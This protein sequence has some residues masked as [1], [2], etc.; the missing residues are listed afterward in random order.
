MDYD[1]FFHGSGPFGPDAETWIKIFVKVT[2]GNTDDS[3]TQL[4]PCCLAP[5]SLAGDWYDELPDSVAWHWPSLLAEFRFR[6]LGSPYTADELEVI[7]SMLPAP[8]TEF[9]RLFKPPPTAS[10]VYSFPAVAPTTRYTDHALERAQEEALDELLVQVTAM[11]KAR[12]EERGWRT[13]MTVCAMGAAWCAQQWQARLK[14]ARMLKKLEEATEAR[15][16]EAQRVEELRAAFRAERAVQRSQFHEE[17]AR[18]REARRAARKAEAEEEIRRREELTRAT[19]ADDAHQRPYT[20]STTTTTPLTPSP[21]TTSTTATMLPTPPHIPVTS[22]QTTVDSVLGTTAKKPPNIPYVEGWGVEMSVPQETVDIEVD[23]V[24]TAIDDRPALTKHPTMIASTTQPLPSS[25]V[26]NDPPP[27][28][29]YPVPNDLPAPVKHPTPELMS[30]TNDH[31]TDTDDRSPPTKPLATRENVS[32][33]ATPPIPSFMNDS[34]CSSCQACP[35]AD[36]DRPAP[37]KHPTAREN[38]SLIGIASTATLIVHDGTR[39]KDSVQPP[40]VGDPPALTKHPTTREIA[41][42]A[43]FA[44][45]P[46]P[47]HEYSPGTTELAAF[48]RSSGTGDRPALTKHPTTAPLAESITSQHSPSPRHDRPALTKHPT[49]HSSI[50][51]T[52]QLP[53]PSDSPPV[54]DC[55]ALTM[56]PTVQG[57]AS[58]AAASANPPP[59]R[60]CTRP[61]C[62]VQPH[63]HDPTR[64]PCV[65]DSLL[66]HGSP[67]GIDDRPPPV[68]HPTPETV[69]LG[70]DGPTAVATYTD[71]RSLANDRPGLTKHPTTGSLSP[72]IIVG[73]PPV[74]S[75]SY[76][77]ES[78]AVV[79]LPHDDDRPALVKHATT[80]PMLVAFSSTSAISSTRRPG[81]DN[82]DR[83]TPVKHPTARESAL[84]AAAKSRSIQV[85][86]DDDRPARTKHPTILRNTHA[87]LSGHVDPCLHVYYDQPAVVKHPAVFVPNPRPPIVPQDSDWCLRHHQSNAPTHPCLL[88]SSLT[89]SSFPLLS[90]GTYGD[91]DWLFTACP[92][93][94]SRAWIH[95]MPSVKMWE[96]GCPGFDVPP[97]FVKL[98]PD[99]PSLWTAH[100]SSGSISLYLI[101]NLRRFHDNAVAQALLL[102]ET[103]RDYVRMPLYGSDL[104]WE[105]VQGYGSFSQM[106]TNLVGLQRRILELY[107]WVFLQEKLQPTIRSIN[108]RP[109]PPP[110]EPV[111]HIDW[112]NGVIVPWESHSSSFD[113]MALEHGVPLWWCDYLADPTQ[114]H[115]PWAGLPGSGYKVFD[116]HR[117]S[118]YDLVTKNGVTET[119]CLQLDP[120]GSTKSLLET[121]VSTKHVEP[122]RFSRV[123]PPVAQVPAIPHLPTAALPLAVPLVL[124]G[125]G[126][127]VPK[128]PLA[129]TE[130]PRFRRMPQAATPAANNTNAGKKK[131]NP[132]KSQRRACRLAAEAA[133]ASQGCSSKHTSSKQTPEEAAHLPAKSS[134]RPL[135]A[136]SSTVSYPRIYSLVLA[137]RILGY[138]EFM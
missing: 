115:T 67:P 112:F 12:R 32:L 3:K 136:P 20:T 116:L 10:F 105:G 72:C 108:P 49:S 1:N 110:R 61:V 6:W 59:K 57:N 8:R 52:T 84:L 58:S 25:R 16:R 37:T 7:A 93:Q 138:F 55:P 90:D 125:R 128:R 5:G 38:A 102:K 106:A 41:S 36:D 95:Y 28:T 74:P 21:C 89:S 130:S 54:N 94:V 44:H 100:G 71:V 15:E 14:R 131:K 4:F 51:S 92:H 86:L 42:F 75:R 135:A 123:A 70:N 76:Q 60:E 33:T 129:D 43:V 2:K 50:M 13:D 97:I 9:S 101:S 26:A 63:T 127:R 122:R 79:R 64:L 69:L 65:T 120:S 83:P 19:S 27:A 34:A 11:Q 88:A 109:P 82:D 98:R 23:G 17:M 66:V 114:S 56:H 39:S 31:P 22:P 85:P 137:H 29:A 73:P 124:L 117:G 47:G 91:H 48:I 35:F 40:A 126:S 104:K 111:P 118:R 24:E 77:A 62:F 45:S 99:K 134:S 68:K 103:A 132:S 133:A 53:L 81:D 113:A 96:G 80:E 119:Y 46:S 78:N 18:A 30:P 87:C 121:I 107:G